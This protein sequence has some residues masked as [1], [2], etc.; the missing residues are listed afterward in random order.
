MITSPLRYED[1]FPES[2]S[3]DTFYP[4]GP[5]AVP[6]DLTQ[7]SKAYKQNAWLAMGMLGLFVLLYLFLSGWFAWTAWRLFAATANGGKDAFMG[8]LVGAFAAFLAVFMLK[9]LFFV[10]H[11]G[12]NADLEITQTEQPRLFAFLHRLADEAGAPRPYR[13][14][15][16][17]RVNA[18]V[19]YDLS[20]LNLI[21]P[22]RKNLEIGL[23]L[24]NVL[25]VGEFKAVCAHEFGHF[26]QRSMAVGRW[27]YIAQQI[28]GHIVAKRD[29]LDRFLDGISRV[30]FRIAWVGW[31]L[32]LIVW[33]LRSLLDTAFTLVVLAQRSLSR[34]MEMQ[35]D[36]VAVSLTGSDALVHALYRLQVADDAWDRTLNFLGD[37]A[38]N[39][40]K[41]DDVF[42]LQ[43]HIIQRM[44][45]LLNVA[46]YGQ[47]PVLPVNDPASHRLFKT[48]IAQPPRMWSTHPLNHEREEN[49]KRIYLPAQGDS[50]SAWDLFDDAQSL[51]AKVSRALITDSEA[52]TVPVAEAESRLDEQFGREYL[53]R[54]YRGAYYGRSP[55]RAAATV[56]DLY[57][58]IE[59]AIVQLDSLYPESLSAELEQ[60]LSLEKEKTLL[61][62]LR[63]GRLDAPGGVI[64]HRGTTIG[65]RALPQA[66]S[67]VQ[68]EIDVLQ[69]KIS[70]H[71][72]MCRTAHR[73]AAAH[74]GKGWE[75]Y[76]YGLAAVLHYA[77]HGE[78]KVRDAQLRLNNV[79]ALTTATGRVSSA[80]RKRLLAEA[81]TFYQIL[82]QAYLQRGEIKLDSSILA[83]MGIEN[84]PDALGELGLLE[85]TSENLG[86]WFKVYESWVGGACNALA[87][88]RRHALEELLSVESKVA[89]LYRAGNT[90]E[91]APEAAPEPSQLPAQYPVLVPGQE[92]RPNTR[93]DWWSRFQTANGLFPAIA[94]L[95][96]AGGIIGAVL[97]FGESVGSTTVTILN[98]LERIVIVD[99]GEQH[100][101]LNPH[102]FRTL[103]MPENASYRITTR[104][105]DGTTIESFEVDVDRNFST[106]V[107]NIAG[108]SPLVEWTAVYGNASPEPS[109]ALGAPRWSTSNAENVFT[110]PPKQISTSGG[111]GTRSVLSAPPGDMYPPQTLNILASEPEREAVIKAHARWDGA[112][113]P[114][115]VYW[116]SM[117]AGTGG[118]GEIIAARLKDDA[119]EV[120]S[121]RLQMDTASSPSERARICSEYATMSNAAPNNADWQYLVLRCN[122]NHAAHSQAFVDAYRKWPDNPWLA[123]AAAYSFAGDRRWKE[124]L[125]AWSKARASEPA[126]INTVSVEMARVRRLVSGSTVDLYSLTEGSAVLRQ[127]LDFEQGRDIED[128]QG[129]A[130][131]QLALGQIEQALGLG[132]G[133]SEQA[134]LLRLAACSEGASGKV[135]MEALN[136]P[137]DQKGAEESLPYMVALAARMRKDTA[138]YAEQLRRIYP[139]SAEALLGFLSLA[140]AGKTA[141]ADRALVGVDPKAL[142]QAWA[143]G[144]VV[145]EK[146]APSA[147]RNGSKRLLFSQERPWFM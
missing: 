133:T 94:R 57:G 90:P 6:A 75:A 131:R 140:Q 41:P 103:T 145:L 65:V 51:R 115:V 58:P 39:K 60:L 32:R 72:R 18:A 113:S 111:G 127:T 13:V 135:I 10:K 108:A 20:I 70:E 147:W 126:L 2:L 81:K 124:A 73:A 59:G 12:K 54:A 109:R 3:M 121:R 55:V 47:E 69:A 50:R 5:A 38:A 99:V 137:P 138:P 89:A 110:E 136:L 1:D 31:L 129:R 114:F 120:I 53:N 62:S 48:E 26:A 144:V 40:R 132:K 66:I 35:A 116:L 146:R 86:E 104:A 84:W 4:A 19:F 29:A 78:A 43:T 134:N 16:T 139:E 106:Y 130:Y 143:M 122:D 92:Y 49:A 67:G 46:D 107:Y 77:D 17:A 23:C 97:A 21:F 42:A 44:R 24:V 61:E 83:R 100:L 142:G 9:A 27:V 101:Q 96:V 118:L 79:L 64:R 105:S 15:L 7:A 33:A 141:E 25:N 93:L 98:G 80:G 30:D 88:L 117:A 123:N 87:F 95:V 119:N 8:A 128:P 63:D 76:L 28:A 45:E 102:G 91:N 112:H 82:Q 52:Q 56:A 34:E 74:I 22:S 11:G 125:S 37:E 14:F 68:T 85:P 71:D 36:R